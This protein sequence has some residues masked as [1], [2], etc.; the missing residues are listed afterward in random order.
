MLA[1]TAVVIA[2]IT[3]SHPLSPSPCSSENSYSS[4][5]TLHMAA[6]SRK[7]F[8]VPPLEL[9]HVQLL[10]PM[11]VLALTCNYSFSFLISLI[12]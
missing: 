9:A 3:H 11:P 4:S 2:W 8:S 7:R 1:Q 12:G 10:I 6:S 5:K